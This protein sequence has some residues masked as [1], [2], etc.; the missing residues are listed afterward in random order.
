MDR[1]AITPFGRISAPPAQ[2]RWPAVA[3]TAFLCV[4]ILALAGGLAATGGDA[5]ARKIAAAGPELTRLLRAMAV[6]KALAA[7]VAAAAILWRLA[8]PVSPA[9]FAAYALAGVAMA[10][11]PGL[12]WDMAHVAAGAVLLHTGLLASVLL[13]WRDP[14]WDRQWAALLNARRARA[15]RR[16]R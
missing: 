5:A 7:T 12:I 6:L 13:L 14:A 8:A 10:A 11:G 1:S 4:L 15:S 16:A 2:L 9:R 3:R